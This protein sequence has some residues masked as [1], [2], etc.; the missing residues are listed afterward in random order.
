MTSQYLKMNKHRMDSFTELK[1]LKEI[2]LYGETKNPEKLEKYVNLGDVLIKQLFR[3]PRIDRGTQ[4]NWKWRIMAERWGNAR[5]IQP[6]VRL[7]YIPETS[8]EIATEIVAKEPSAVVSVY[9][10]TSVLPFQN[11]SVETA[12]FENVLHEV[13]KKL[14]TEDRPTP[15]IEEDSPLGKAKTALNKVL[16]IRNLRTARDCDKIVDTSDLDFDPFD[17]RINQRCLYNNLKHR[18]PAAPHD[19][20]K[21][22]GRRRSSIRPSRPE[23]RRRISSIKNSSGISEEAG[24]PA[25][26]PKTD[27]EPV[28]RERQ[29]SGAST[30]KASRQNRLSFEE[31]DASGQ[32]TD[33]SDQKKGGKTRRRSSQKVPAQQGKSESMAKLEE[34]AITQEVEEL[35][36]ETADG[37]VA[38]PD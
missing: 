5:I 22:F 18:S 38:L 36:P 28:P 31:K 24:Q 20:T 14:N 11:S 19:T 2:M 13:A 15:V 23:S 21:V 3:V 25:Q 26:V 6:K 29:G 17:P 32:Q 30:R 8:P 12:N 10:K 27:A 37:A 4:T 9:D 33:A 7:V 35:Q 1:L 34:G 16:E